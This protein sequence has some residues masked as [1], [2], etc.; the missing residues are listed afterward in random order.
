MCN[1]EF[2]LI[3]DVEIKQTEEIK[4]LIFC[5]SY[6]SSTSDELNFFVKYK[7]SYVQIIMNELTYFV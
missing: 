2:K 4:T 1:L 3:N 7:E 5:F 6:D